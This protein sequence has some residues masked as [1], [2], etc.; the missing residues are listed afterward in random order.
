[1]HALDK[2]KA[3]PF[4]LSHAEL[5][6]MSMTLDEATKTDSGPL[7]SAITHVREAAASLTTSTA[8]I[9]EKAFPIGALGIAMASC[10]S[11]YRKPDRIGRTTGQVILGRNE[12]YA[13]HLVHLAAI[14]L[15]L[16]QAQEI[17]ANELSDTFLAHLARSQASIDALKASE[18][19]LEMAKDKMEAAEKRLTKA[20]GEKERREKQEEARQTKAAFEQAKM[21]LETRAFMLQNSEHSGPDSGVNILSTYVSLQMQYL[22]T[23]RAIFVDAQRSFLSS[24]K[25][26]DANGSGKESNAFASS[27]QPPL[28]SQRSKTEG[29]SNVVT[30]G[31]ERARS[32]PQIKKVPLAAAPDTASQT[33]K[34]PKRLPLPH[35][36]SASNMFRDSSALTRDD[37]KDSRK[38]GGATS[39]KASLSYGAAKGDEAQ[40]A[41]E[42]TSGSGSVSRGKS[43]LGTLGVSLGRSSTS[44]KMETGSG[45][46]SL[47]ESASDKEKDKDDGTLSTSRWKVKNPSNFLKSSRIK[48]RDT[49]GFQAVSGDVFDE[50]CHHHTK[51][52]SHVKE[53][54]VPGS[55]MDMDGILVTTQQSQSPLVNGH[56]VHQEGRQA[57]GWNLDRTRPPA[58]EGMMPRFS[59]DES[60]HPRRWTHFGEDSTAV[61]NETI[62]S[63]ANEGGRSSNI[64]FLSPA[65]TSGPFH[66]DHPVDEQWT[67]PAA[68]S[69]ARRV[70]NWSH[71]T[72][73][74]ESDPFGGGGTGTAGSSFAGGHSPGLSPQTTGAG[75]ADVPLL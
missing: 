6:E 1:M 27:S 35:T 72:T 12:G 29:A 46:T 3:L 7:A 59:D 64:R 66:L 51:E 33:D 74:S 54:S 40:I 31:R 61:A 57:E 68:G 71:N 5:L 67:G 44:L 10:A 55:E 21:D 49:D 20:R 16:A 25:T 17:F 65:S 9:K 4:D 15:A 52:L 24:T 69:Q 36:L 28:A 23:Q 58:E 37:S 42:N 70:S 62:P 14:H 43:L 26:D 63:P 50:P 8:S 45:A 38:E 41:G 19:S 73:S 13:S 75:A 2:R 60:L 56:S 32:S 11:G 22:E 34:A 47:Q 18:R 30:G 53:V 48:T 39:S